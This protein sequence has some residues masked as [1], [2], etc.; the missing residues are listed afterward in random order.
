MPDCATVDS[1]PGVEVASVKGMSTGL[2]LSDA[3]H[4]SLI[5][6]WE[7]AIEPFADLAESL[8]EEQWHA[9]S[10]LPGWTNA[11]VVAH[12]IGIERDL[13]GDPTPRLT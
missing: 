9:A 8:T 12:V 4:A 2:R 7:S 3:D 10:G 13:L 1:D 5:E 6:A 11:D